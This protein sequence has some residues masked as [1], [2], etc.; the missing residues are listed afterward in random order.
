MLD[1]W[2]GLHPAGNAP[3]LAD[4]SYWPGWDIARGFAIF[5]DGAGGYVLDGWGGVHPVGTAPA[6]G[7]FAYWP[8]W[9]I[10]RGIAL[11]PWSSAASPQGWVLDGWGALHPFGGAPELQASAYWHGWDIARGIVVTPDSTPGHV[12]GLVLDGWGAVHPFGNG[13]VP[14]APTTSNYWRGLDIARGLTL[15]PAST[16]AA[17]AGYVLDG[18]GGLSSFG[19][20]LAVSPGASWPG[21]DIARGI[22]SWSGSSPSSPGGWVVDGWGGLHPFGSAPPVS[23]NAYWRGWDIVRGFAGPGSGSATRPL[24]RRILPVPAYVQVYALSCEAAA[25]QMALAYEGIGATQTQILNTIGID[26]RPHFIDSLGL[27]RWGD[28]YQA[29]VGNPSGS[30]ASWTGYGTYNSAIARAGA[31]LGG[32]ILSSNE[33]I[34]PNSVYAAIVNGHPVVVW[35]AFDWRYHQPTQYQAFD[36]RWVQFGLPY[37]HAATVVGVTDSAVLVNNPIGGPQWV[38]KAAFEAAFATFGDMA[39]TLA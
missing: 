24:T 21:W 18:Y 4:T 9:D 26:N 23:G 27:F 6:V 5:P 39:V 30:E 13:G 19:G 7:G 11:A 8:G 17:M 16:G 38:G 35:I 36:G 34:S 22:T 3:N 37:E 32:H 29:F 12:S 2:G 31:S 1:G 25:L 14:A 15:L 10:A 33:G 28:P 20:A